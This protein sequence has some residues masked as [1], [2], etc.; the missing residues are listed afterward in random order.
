MKKRLKKKRRNICKYRSNKDVFHL[1]ISAARICQIENMFDEYPS[2]ITNLIVYGSE[3]GKEPHFHLDCDECNF[4][5]AIRLDVPEYYK[6]IKKINKLNQKQLILLNSAL[7][8]FTKIPGWEE[9]TNW[10]TACDEWNSS[11][12]NTIKV[13]CKTTMKPD[14]FVL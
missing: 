3:Y 14:Y 6:D 7:M 12:D 13:S 8:S 2:A 10:E 5:T 11:C 1:E 9:N 4:H